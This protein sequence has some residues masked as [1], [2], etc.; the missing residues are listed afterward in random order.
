MYFV[1]FVPP[2]P[3][4]KATMYFPYLVLPRFRPPISTKALKGIRVRRAE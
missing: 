2:F 3:E 4:G 1:D